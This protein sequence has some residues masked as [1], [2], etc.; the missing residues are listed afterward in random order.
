MRFTG[1]ISDNLRGFYRMKYQDRAGQ[2]RYAG[3]SM[4]CVSV[5]SGRTFLVLFILHIVFPWRVVNFGSLVNRETLSMLKSQL[6]SNGLHAT[7][8]G[9]SEIWTHYSLRESHVITKL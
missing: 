8:I 9:F 2:S 3:V 4:L 7:T 5:T 6:R 1:I